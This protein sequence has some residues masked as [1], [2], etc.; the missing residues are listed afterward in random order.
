M[1]WNYT[2]IFLAVYRTG[3]A[4]KAALM[5]GMSE[6]TLFR[7]LSNYERKTGQLFIRHSRLSYTL[8]KLGESILSS[9]LEIESLYA[10]MEREIDKRD[11]LASAQVI[12]TAPTSYSYFIV[13]L[14]I[15]QLAQD[16]PEIRIDLKVSN[17]NLSLNAHQADI[18]LR[19][20]NTP[21][22]NYIGRKV[23][24]VGWSVFCSQN[25]EFESRP[26]RQ[27]HELAN[28]RIIGGSGELATIPAYEWIEKN[29]VENCVTTSDDFFALSH[30]VKCNQGIAILPD[31]FELHPLLKLFS[32]E[33]FLKNS[34]WVLKHRDV[35]QVKRVSLVE[36]CLI[37]IL[38]DKLR[39]EKHPR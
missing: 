3:S 34:L 12:L 35:R 21:P 17:H 14:L 18:A 5:L 4:T 33:E 15:N 38:A 29:C 25:Y 9:A 2:K 37:K 13:P 8:T 26:P 11:D 10:K 24:S 20:T 39:I 19:V 28:Y 22:N 7:H 32:V 23:T 27:L 1:D 36:K 16:H 6:S 30:L 31:E